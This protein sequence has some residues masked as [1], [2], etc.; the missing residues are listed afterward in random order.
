MT[1]DEQDN[2]DQVEY[3]N[4]LFHYIKKEEE[5]KRIKQEKEDAERR[6]EEER[7][8]KNKG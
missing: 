1:N 7:N 2:K 5:E 6:I 8:K 3:G 4:D